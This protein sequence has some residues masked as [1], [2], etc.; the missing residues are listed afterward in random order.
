M[1]REKSEALRTFVAI[2]IKGKREREK[3]PKK[4]W[5]YAI[6]SEYMRTARVRR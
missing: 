6:E 4:K 5:L 2:N 1:R 3:P